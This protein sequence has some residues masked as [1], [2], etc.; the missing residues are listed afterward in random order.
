MN[1]QVAHIAG[2]S[3]TSWRSRLQF[4]LPAVRRTTEQPQNQI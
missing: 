3:L 2:D 1:L 4:Q